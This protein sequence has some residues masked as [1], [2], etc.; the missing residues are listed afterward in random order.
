MYKYEMLLRILTVKYLNNQNQSHCTVQY[1]HE[2]CTFDGS[3]NSIKIR[4][5][6]PK[7]FTLIYR[8]VL[9]LAM[10]NSYSIYLRFVRNNESTG[11]Q[12]TNLN[13]RTAVVTS[14]TDNIQQ[15]HYE[16]STCWSKPIEKQQRTNKPIIEYDT[17]SLFIA[18]S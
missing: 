2:Q 16:T 17:K 4:R 18:F 9:D 6:E 15:T 7:V 14:E 13:F 8:Y 1:I 11:S 10:S 12:L 3:E 5:K